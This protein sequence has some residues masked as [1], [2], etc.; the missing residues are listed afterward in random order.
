MPEFNIAINDDIMNDLKNFYQI[1]KKLSLRYPDLV[2]QLLKEQPQCEEWE[3]MIPDAYS[4][5][6][7]FRGEQTTKKDKMR[8]KME[9]VAIMVKHVDHDALYSDKPL[10]KG[11]RSALA[12]VLGEKPIQ[13]S[14]TL[15]TVKNQL[16]IYKDFQVAVGYLYAELFDK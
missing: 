12:K 16:C 11:V 1:G 10:K 8:H 3:K 2:E 14:N 15:K 4:K 9:F 5:F 13:I 6:K 7:A